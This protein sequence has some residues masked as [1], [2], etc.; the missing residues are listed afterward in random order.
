MVEKK[1]KAVETTQPKPVEIDSEHVAVVLPV[2]NRPDLLQQCLS[3]LADQEF[4]SGSCEILVC[5]DGSTVDLVSAVDA[6]RTKL[7]GIRLLHQPNRGPASA[8]NLGFRSSKASI[9]VCVDS[10]VVCA[11]GFLVKLIGG[12]RRNPDWVAAEA[13]VL[14]AGEQGPF[15]DA[16]FNYGG[17]Y[18]TGASAYKAAALLEVG[19]LDEA[20]PFP[21]C[22]DAELAARLLKLGHYGYVPDA[23]VY[24]PTRRVTWRLRWRS[25]QYW[26]YTMILAKRYGFLAFPGHPA[27]PFPRLRVALAAILTLPLGRLI[28]GCRHLT[29][30]PLEGI[31]ACLYA[32][33]DLFCGVCAFK[34]ILFTKVPMRKNYLA[35]GADAEFKDID[36]EPPLTA[37]R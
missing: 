7:P 16:P 26:R 10:D 1:C 19:G 13:T 35:V 37:T 21:A 25:R 12:L 31:T 34:D 15:F 22:E 30:S 28:E 3:S 33:F 27:G 2:H 8:R 11:P 14:P 36:A 17:A 23:V 9:F 5:D 6:F 24:H 20:F 29:R 18:G 4:P 32:F